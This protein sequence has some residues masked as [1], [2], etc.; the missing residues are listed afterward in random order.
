MSVEVIIIK[1]CSKCGELKPLSDFSQDRRRQ[2]GRRSACKLCAA[3]YYQENKDEIAARLLRYRQENKDKIAAKDARR[4]ARKNGLPNDWTAKDEQYAFDYFEGL[5][6]VCGKPLNGFWHTGAM[7]H[8]IPITADV[9]DNPGTV[10]WNMVPLCHGIDGC[11]NSKNAK[12]PEEWLIE[13]YG[14]R[15][16]GQ[17]I[18]RIEAFFDTVRQVETV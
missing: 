4:R 7:D 17:I 11:N 14:K 18:K 9:E 1:P 5:C 3:R 13:Q 10:P 16:A 8:W 12:M 6:A 15:K 2:D